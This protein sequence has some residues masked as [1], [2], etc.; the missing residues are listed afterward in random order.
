MAEQDEKAERVAGGPLG[1]MVGKAKEAIGSAIG[2]EELSQ[3]GRVQ[4][5]QVDTEQE[6]AERAGE[7]A[8]KEE[9]AEIAEERSET[10]ARR[11]ELEHPHHV[12]VVA[13]QRVRD[14]AEGRDVRES[15]R[16]RA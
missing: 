3:E 8:K 1:K 7:A 10:Q 6:A 9:R 15:D 14:V 13:R 11:R 4:Q 12:V 2:N 16:P 5:V